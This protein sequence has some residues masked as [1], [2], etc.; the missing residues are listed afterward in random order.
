[1]ERAR[2]VRPPDVGWLVYTKL[3]PHPP[4]AD[5][6]ARPRLLGALWAAV[7]TRPL[8]LVSAPAGYGKTTLLAT[9]PEACPELPLAWL[10]LDEE[11]NDPV[12]FLTALIA[13]LQRLDPACGATA[14]ALLASLPRPAAEAR[15]VVG[16]LINDVLE[17]MPAPFALVLDDLHLI[18]EPAV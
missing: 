1:M 9:L 7:T 5:V 14:R 4:R 15:R 12:R 10:T 13:A 18:A 8:T 3:Q 6:V 17:A 2:R 11:D 16:V